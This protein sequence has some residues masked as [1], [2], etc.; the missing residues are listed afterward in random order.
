V[1]RAPAR[2]RWHWQ[3]LFG[4]YW[5]HTHPLAGEDSEGRIDGN[6]LVRTRPPGTALR[7]GARFTSY[8]DD[9]EPYAPIHCALDTTPDVCWHDPPPQTN[10]RLSEPVALEALS[11]VWQVRYQISSEGIVRANYDG[12]DNTA[13][14]MEL[15]LNTNGSWSSRGYRAFTSPIPIETGTWQAVRDS[16]R[17]EILLTLVRQ[18]RLPRVTLR[19]HAVPGQLTLFAVDGGVLMKNFLRSWPP[20]DNSADDP[21]IIFGLKV[22]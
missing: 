2:N 3:L 17:N 15:R 20:D 1:N 22:E 13:I 10:D 14:V 9:G 11:G 7:A 8:G 6:E 21:Q 16:K 5:D 18:N 12:Y 4:A 19:A